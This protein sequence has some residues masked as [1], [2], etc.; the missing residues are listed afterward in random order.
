MSAGFYTNFYTNL[1]TLLWANCS[2]LCIASLQKQFGMKANH[3]ASGW[4]TIG[5][6]AQYKHTRRHV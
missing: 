3:S 4:K 6:P 2:G 1:Y 5:E